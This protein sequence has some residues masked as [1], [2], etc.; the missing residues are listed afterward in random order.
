VVCRCEEVPLSRIRAAVTELGATDARGVKGLCRTGMGWC[1]GRVC[2]YATAALTAHLCGRT[3]D[4]AD[5]ASFAHRPI[6]TPVPL[7]ELAADSPGGGA[8]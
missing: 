6:A 5:L 8:G 1:Q 4:P 7:G 2:G 3:L